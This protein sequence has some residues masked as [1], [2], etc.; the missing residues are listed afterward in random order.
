MPPGFIRAYTCFFNLSGRIIKRTHLFFLGGLIMNYRSYDE[1]YSRSMDD[2]EGFWADAAEAVS[3]VKKWDSVV[4][5]LKPEF[6]AGLK[7]LK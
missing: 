6:L 5:S 1:A 3:W 7:A 4:S 2:P